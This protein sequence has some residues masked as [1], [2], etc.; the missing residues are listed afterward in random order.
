MQAVAQLQRLGQAD[1]EPTQALPAEDD[2]AR[3]QF[4]PTRASVLSTGT[5]SGP[6]RDP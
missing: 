4:L 6:A 5:R 2:S 1:D 3:A